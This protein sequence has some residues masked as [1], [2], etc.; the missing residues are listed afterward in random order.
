MGAMKAENTGF[1]LAKRRFTAGYQAQDN[2]TM[3]P[4]ASRCAAVCV[5]MLAV[6][7]STVAAETASAPNPT[8][9]AARPRA[10]LPQRNLTLELRAIAEPAPAPASQQSWA[11][12]PGDAEEWQKLTLA[13]GEKAQFAFNASQAWAWTGAALRGNG[14]GSVDGV[15]Q[16]LHWATDSRTLEC[17]VAWAGGN[18]PAR[19]EVTVQ[20][21]A[22]GKGAGDGAVPQNRTQQVRT[23]VWVPLGE[24]FTLARSGPRPQVSVEGSYSSRTAETGQA[25]LLQV[26]VL[27]PD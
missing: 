13:N 14:A 20:V 7:S 9:S 21:A 5:C 23:V 18:K 22:S 25:Q 11:T 1:F 6:W 19:V 8:A 16:S 17:Q 2:G 3:Y 15:S 26:R 12:A 4:F 10:A 24:W 27:A